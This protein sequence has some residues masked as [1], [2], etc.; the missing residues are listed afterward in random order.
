MPGMMLAMG[1]IWVLVVVVLILFLTYMRARC[2]QPSAGAE[3]RGSL[4][5]RGVAPKQHGGGPAPR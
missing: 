1:L 5:T 4:A 3:L 2:R